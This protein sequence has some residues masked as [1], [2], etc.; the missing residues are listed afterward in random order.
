MVYVEL[1]ASIGQRARGFLDRLFFFFIMNV[2]NASV[3]LPCLFVGSH[4]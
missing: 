3:Y 1:R 2:L 4:L